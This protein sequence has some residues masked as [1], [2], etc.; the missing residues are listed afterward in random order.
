MVIDLGEIQVLRGLCQHLVDARNFW[1][2][3]L[4]IPEAL[5]SFAGAV[6]VNI[7]FPDSEVHRA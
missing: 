7:R 4:W 1:I 5:L 3:A 6:G 2:A